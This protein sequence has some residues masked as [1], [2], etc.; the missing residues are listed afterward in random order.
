MDKQ[1][2]GMNNAVWTTPGQGIFKCKLGM[3]IRDDRENFIRAQTMS[4][5]GSPLLREAK[6][7]SLKEALH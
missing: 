4:R 5:N 1:Q 2:I 7:W 3:C 6:A